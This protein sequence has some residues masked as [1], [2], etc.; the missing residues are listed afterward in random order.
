MPLATVTL[1]SAV[2]FFFTLPE[3]FLRLLATAAWHGNYSSRRNNRQKP[4]LGMAWHCIVKYGMAR[5]W[6]GLTWS[7]VH[8]MAWYGMA[9]IWVAFHGLW[10]C[11]MTWHCMIW[12][13]NQLNLY[14]L[15]WKGKEQKQIF[16]FL[17]IWGGGGFPPFVVVNISCRVFMKCSWMHS[18][19]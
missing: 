6:Y 12:S 19:T 15:F 14:Y 5:W 2:T 3:F 16:H 8:S 1:L 7:V 11:G 18:A 13:Q 17:W 9:W 4:W 10:W